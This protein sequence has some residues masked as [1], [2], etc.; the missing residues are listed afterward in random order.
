[1]AH[2]E[3]IS[4]QPATAR[5]HAARHLDHCCGCEARP[6]GPPPALPTAR[7]WAQLMLATDAPAT[8][9]YAPL[10]SDAGYAYLL[11]SIGVQERQSGLHS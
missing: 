1:M 11:D 5:V 10:W 9:W 6:A 2:I 7:L 3:A 4:W 8:A